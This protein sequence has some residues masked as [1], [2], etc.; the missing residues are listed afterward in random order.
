MLD[1]TGGFETYRVV[2]PI[3]MSEGTIPV[4]SELSL[5][6]V[7]NTPTFYFNGGLLPPGYQVNFMNLLREEKARGWNYLQP[8]RSIHNKV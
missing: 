6:Y 8:T 5:V 1:N 7:L 2:K 3:V 4:N